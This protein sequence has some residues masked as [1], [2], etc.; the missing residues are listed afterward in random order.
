MNIYDYVVIKIIALSPNKIIKI[1]RRMQINLFSIKVIKNELYL[2]VRTK[3]LDRIDK[4]YDYE[5]VRRY[6]LSYF[7]FNIRAILNK[8]IFMILLFSFIF[9]FS[10][11]I[12][13]VNI[14][15]SDANLRNR[16]LLFLEDYGIKGYRFKVNDG[17]ISDIKNIVLEKFAEDIEW[18]NISRVG[19]I[20]DI[21]LQERVTKNKNEENG[22]CHI[23]AK[24]DGIIKRIISSAGDAIVDVNDSV[25]KD[26]ILI[27]GEI[28]ANDEVKANVCADGKVYASTWYTIDISIPKYYDK[29]VYLKDK[30]YNLS[31]SYNNKSVKIFKDRLDSFKSFKKSVINAFGV[32]LFLIKDISVSVTRVGYS[33]EE[34]DKKLELLVLEKMK[35][36]IGE[37]GVI[38]KRNVLKKVDKDS[39]IDIELFI[40]AEEEIGQTLLF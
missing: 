20:Y 26:D 31:V 4:L 40:E 23:I 14:S 24:K 11:F 30:R 39:K 6:G 19:M 32:E 34:L 3:D 10:M 38:I 21:Q 8:I 35:N 25:K 36:V 12:L 9:I 2:K 28:K 22:N 37:D 33:E 7:I 13:K 29:V 15:V 17:K 1:L 18:I 5:I 16:L 27:S